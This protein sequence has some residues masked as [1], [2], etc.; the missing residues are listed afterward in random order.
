MCTLTIIPLSVNDERRTG[1]IGAGIRVVCNRDESRLRP[2]A[3]SPQ[4]RTFGVRSAYLPVDPISDGTWIAASDAA[5][6]FVLMNVYVEPRQKVLHDVGAAG[7]PPTVSRGGIIPH[8]LQADSLQHAR[9]IAESMDHRR[10]EPFRLLIA[11]RVQFVEFVW[12]QRLGRMEEPKPI[13]QPLFF[14]SSGLGDDVVATPRRRLFQEYFAPGRD[15]PA[16]QDA[17]H[18]HSWPDNERMSVWMTRPEALTVSRTEIELGPN[19]ITMS[20][21]ARVADSS[22]LVDA[23]PV[24][25]PIAVP[26]D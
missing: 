18:H 13:Q 20:Y 15:W 23:E 4:L 5:L 26:I 17:F 14:T 1:S 9:A 12:A 6:V 16:S 21:H 7:A 24:S 8:L 11:D 25:L 10:F 2:A 3:L 19:Q 22:K